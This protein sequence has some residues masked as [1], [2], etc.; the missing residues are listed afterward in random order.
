[1]GKITTFLTEVKEELKKVTWPSKDDTVGTTAVVIVLV[2]VI[3]VFLGVVDAG[4]S[5]LF[6]LL[7]G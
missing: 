4:L 2:I 7:I 1:M 5:R 3:S 6:N